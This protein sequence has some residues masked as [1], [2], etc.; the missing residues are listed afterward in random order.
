MSD[1]LVTTD[2]LED[3]A[4]LDVVIDNPRGNILTTA[5]MSALSAVLTEHEASTSLRLM[6]LR[7]A[8]KHFS[9]GAS[10]EEHRRDQAPAMLE[11][12][13]ALARQLA[14]YP[15]PIAAT[16]QGKCLGGAFEVIL[17]CHFV[18]A[19]ENAS[20]GCPEIKLGVFP[21]VLAA[22]GALQLGG[23]RATRLLLTGDTISAETGVHIGLVSAVVDS[24][25]PLAG[26][27]QWYRQHLAP[28]SPFAI[29]QASRAMRQGSGLLA[30]LDEPLRRAERQYVNEVV[31]SEDGNEGIEAFIERRQP[32]W[33]GR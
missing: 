8:G 19:T 21:P 30:A 33:K 10:V 1:T 2:L 16:V 23:M 14:A 20:M 25:D 3:G 18:F 11:T 28:L 12:F 27:L 22:C 17:C 5:V 15:V 4:V 13:H 26:V 29:R 9:F 31:P 24:A 6:V 7:A 32:V